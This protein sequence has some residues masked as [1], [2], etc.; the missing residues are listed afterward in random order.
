MNIQYELKHFN[1]LTTNELYEVL[2]LRTDVFVVEQNCP[3]PECDNKDQEAY[4]LLAY[5]ENRELMAYVRILAPGVSYKDPA[6]GRVV[7]KPEFRLHKKGHE[8]M[9]EAIEHTTKLFGTTSITISA[10]QH[11]EKFYG[12]LGFVS[13][14]EM[15]LEDNIPHVKM[16]FGS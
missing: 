13:K 12:N 4:H 10:Q 2:K 15:Y 5:T 6:I 14:G 3:Y 8:L 9:Q 16:V 1:Q 11:L 7:V